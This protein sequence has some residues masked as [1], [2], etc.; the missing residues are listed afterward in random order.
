MSTRRGSPVADVIAGNLAGRYILHDVLSHGTAPL[1][2]LSEVDL[3]IFEAP[4]VSRPQFEHTMLEAVQKVRALGPD[5]MVVV[6]PSLRRKSTKALWVSKWNYLA[7]A[8][9]KFCQTCSCRTGN[10][11]AGCHLTCFVGCSSALRTEPCAEIPTLSATTQA[12]LESFGGTICNL[13]ASLYLVGKKTGD[14]LQVEAKGLKPTEEL[15]PVLATAQTLC[16]S[17]PSGVEPQQAPDSALHTALA[18]RIKPDSMAHSKTEVAYPTDAKE[19]EKAKRKEEKECEIE[20][21]SR[22]ERK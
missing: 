1:H 16:R 10:K 13:T 12:S 4:S 9:F 7:Q 15:S 22:N 20:K 14:C 17:T 5:V 6:Q 11:V 3:V 18:Q 2:E 8:P 21:Q 19:R